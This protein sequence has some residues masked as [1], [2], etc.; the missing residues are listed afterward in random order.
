[1]HNALC[2]VTMS[3]SDVMRAGSSNKRFIFL[4]AATCHSRDVTEKQTSEGEVRLGNRSNRR[5]VSNSKISYSLELLI[6]MEIN[7]SSRHW[8]CSALLAEN[9]EKL[10]C[11]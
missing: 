2:D 1:M 11:S 10:M 8:E 6:S 9:R 3:L 7:L 5:L 4:D